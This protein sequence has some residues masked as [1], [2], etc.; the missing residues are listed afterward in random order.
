MQALV[1][2]YGRRL[3]PDSVRVRNVK[4]NTASRGAWCFEYA[5]KN[6]DGRY[7]WWQKAS[8]RTEGIETNPFPMRF[9]DASHISF[10]DNV[11]LSRSEEFK[12]VVERDYAK[13]CLN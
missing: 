8:I 1:A 13:D 5:A 7:V 10:E 11:D 12:R 3:N 2:K 9:A 4:D 6:A